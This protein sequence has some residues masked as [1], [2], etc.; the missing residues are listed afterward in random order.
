MQLFELFCKTE[1][2]F[3]FFSQRLFEIFDFFEIVILGR[4]E[5]IFS[6]G[7]SLTERSLR[8]WLACVLVHWQLERT[9]IEQ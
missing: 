1:L 7:N 9:N 2:S 3:G 4:D 5:Y 8:H 6:S